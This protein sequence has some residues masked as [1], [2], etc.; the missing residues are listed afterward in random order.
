M[1]AASAQR[2]VTSRAEPPRQRARTFQRSLFTWPQGRS[3]SREQSSVRCEELGSRCASPTSAKRRT[4]GSAP[5]FN[6]TPIPQR[7]LFVRSQPAGRPLRASA[8]ARCDTTLSDGLHHRPLDSTNRRVHPS[9]DRA[10]R[11]AAC[12]RS[13]DPTIQAQSTVRPRAVVRIAPT[14]RHPLHAHARPRGAAS[15]AQ[16]FHEYGLAECQ[17]PRLRRLHADA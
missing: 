9:A 12:R 17:L 5:S 10:R 7:P 13:N 3:L 15:S 16:R 11:A 8:R 1:S 6:P 4:R 14:C 2:A